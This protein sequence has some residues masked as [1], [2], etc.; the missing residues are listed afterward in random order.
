MKLERD[1]VHYYSQK[2][3]YF[4]VDGNSGAVHQLD[5]LA[6]AIISSVKE[7]LELAKEPILE[8]LEREFSH[9]EIKEAFNEILD[10]VNEGLLFSKDITEAPKHIDTVVKALCLNVAHDCNLRCKYC[11]ASTGDF[12]GERQLMSLEV[13][14]QAV[15]FLI[16]QSG[17]RK[18]IEIDFFGGEPLMNFQ[19]V[20]D[21]VAYGEQ[22]AREAGKHI[23][24]TLTT[25]G[26]G[27]TPEIQEFLN[28][29][30]YNV[31][32]SIDGRSEVNDDNRRTISG[33]GSV[34]EA[35][36]PKYQEFVANRGNKSYYVR[37]TFTRDNLDFT[38]DILHL[39][40]LGFEQLSM[41]PVVADS[42]EAYAL[43]DE[44]LPA[45][46]DEYSRLADALVERIEAQEPVN[47]FHFNVE[48]KKGP[49]L[50][51]RLSGCGAGH[52]YLAVTPEGDLYPCHQFIGKTQYKIGHVATG[53]N[54]PS[55]GEE[56]KNAHVLNK[57]ECSQCWA[58]YY[59]SGG[60]HANNLTF[61]Q[62]LHTPYHISC[63]MEKKRLECSFY[64]HSVIN[65]YR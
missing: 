62:D 57:P 34:Y 36:V 19:V 39:A 55:L 9:E 52:E 30:M 56:F 20:K 16:K 53:I 41:E 29:K 35:I 65:N 61:N 10:L 21:T 22:R 17:T 15:D 64:I 44:D 28:E 8:K 5:E 48:L 27:L 50:Y 2:G 13:A 54:L 63:I 18:Q 3:Q 32:L 23:R 51:K 4:A 7:G 24:F 40:D 38:E 31:V 45:I 11:F 37:G 25:N 14:K 6:Y 59:C 1:C 58:K 33:K 60:C 46:L 47:F 26:I 43:R 12:G 49:C 42:S